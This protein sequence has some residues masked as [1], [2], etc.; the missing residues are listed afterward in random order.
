MEAALQ[1][2]SELIQYI[3]VGRFVSAA[4]IMLNVA[5][6]AGLLDYDEVRERL[7]RLL[8]AARRRSVDDEEVLALRELVAEH[9]LDGADEAL[10]Q[11]YMTKEFMKLLRDVA[12]LSPYLL[13]MF[14]GFIASSVDTILSFR[15]NMFL[16]PMAKVVRYMAELK[17]EELKEKVTDELIDRVFRGALYLRLLGVA[18][19]DAKFYQE[20]SRQVRL[21]GVAAA[22]VQYRE[23]FMAPPLKEYAPAVVVE[24]SSFGEDGSVRCLYFRPERI[25][26]D[27]KRR[28]GEVPAIFICGK[29]G[30]GKTTMLRALEF[31]YSLRG[32]NIVDLSYDPYRNQVLYAALPQSDPEIVEFAQKCCSYQPRPCRVVV[33]TNNVR[34]AAGLASRVSGSIEV[35]EFSL[36]AFEGLLKRRRGHYITVI[37]DS[38]GDY[39][40]MAEA[41]IEH[42]LSLKMTADVKCAFAFDEAHM[43]LP[44]FLKYSSF[45][46][47]LNELIT[48]ARGLG[49]PLIFTT[50]RPSMVNKDVRTTCNVYLIGHL[51]EADVSVVLEEVPDIEEF[52]LSVIKSADACSHKIFLLGIHYDHKRCFVKPVPPPHALETL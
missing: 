46:A 10:F 21:E 17:G 45:R 51:S 32:Y 34:F 52:E 6:Y 8:R 38:K 48:H 16:L 20:F 35:K 25:N 26:W 11:Y 14:D 1:T 50:Q 41:M 29:K 3:M 9:G 18:N 33:L 49:T 42:Y 27:V 31:Y 36:R 28:T 47:A 4:E 22:M 13:D 43:V 7:F 30:S 2:L 24:R 12:A 23:K 5:E 15:E 37:A 44:R 19:S 39:Y 40:E